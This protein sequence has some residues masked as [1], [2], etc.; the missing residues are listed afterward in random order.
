MGGREQEAGPARVLGRRC[1]LFSSSGV[2]GVGF[3]RSSK[4]GEPLLAGWVPLL[5]AAAPARR[6][7]AVEAVHPSVIRQPAG[8]SVVSI[9]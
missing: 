9:E 7:V 6:A 8:P 5:A 1:A 2:G 3:A 4:S